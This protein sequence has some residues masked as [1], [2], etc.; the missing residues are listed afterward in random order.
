MRKIPTSMGTQHPD[1]AS[2]YVSIR[3]EAAEAVEALTPAPEGLG[4]EEFMIDFEGKMT[5]YHQTADIA[6]QLIAKGLLPGRDVW[7]TPRI[8]NAT[9]ETVFRQLMAL[10]SIIEA[11]YDIMRG[12][13]PA[14]GIEEVILPMVKG[15]GDLINIRGRIADIMELAHKE[16]GMERDPNALGVIPLIEDIPNMLGFAKF[17]RE[18]HE[19]CKQ[20]GFSNSRLRFMIAR[21][22]PAVIYGLVASVLAARIIIS[23]AAVLGDDLELESAPIYGGGALPFRGHVRVENLSNL[24]KNFSGIKTVTIQSGMRYDHEPGAAAQAAAILRR[25]LPGSVARRFTP[26]E[27]VFMKD[28]L[29][30][31]ATEYMSKF[32]QVVELAG[33]I[34]DIIPQQRDRLTRRGPTGYARR[35]PDPREL[36]G[37]VDDIG[38]D[39]RLK[40]I[41]MP[42]DRAIPRAITFTAALYTVG[43]PPE[44][45]GVGDGLAAVAKVHGQEGIDQLLDIYPAL[46]HDIEF[47]S[48][49][50]SL[51]VA[52]RFFSHEFM[53]ALRRGLSRTQE[54]LDISVLG[55]QDQ[56]YETLLEIIEPL[57]RQ[58]I[59]GEAL[60]PEDEVLLKSCTVRLG[61][62]RG[63]LG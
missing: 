21:S 40:A 33:K 22:D 45:L 9:E 12:D 50:L 36:C 42:K 7:L 1:S 44:F 54:Y 20:K 8:S 41:K 47:A 29:V 24:I 43:I 32:S 59:R 61:K 11:D 16:F 63:S 31:F 10:M 19:F 62:L 37:L 26:D 27:A 49:F 51:K 55:R 13:E 57:V 56:A 39:A 46:T 30:R 23:D 34:S 5:P 48:R 25:E 35:P 15:A 14:G 52:K 38:L 2:R 6:H 53:S 3:E 58:A 4:L 18:Y 28:V 17:F 60:G